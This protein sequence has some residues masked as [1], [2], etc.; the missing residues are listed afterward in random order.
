MNPYIECPTITTKS[1]TIR[2][3]RAS[4]SKALFRCYHDKSAVEY[5]NDDNC[6]FGFYVDSEAR[7][8]ETIGYWIDFYQKQYF[9]RFAIVD[10]ATEAAVGTIEGFCGE[11]G[12]LRVDICREY[13]KECYLSELFNFAREH[14]YA[15]FGNEYIVTKAISKASERCAALV[16]NKWE[17]IDTFRGL[18]DYYRIKL[19]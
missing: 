15:L 1:F 8:Q 14:F 17:P 6:D 11:T 12:V 4:D 2:L 19:N 9:V 3:I 10:L 5:M 13:E 16:N 18:H 7:M